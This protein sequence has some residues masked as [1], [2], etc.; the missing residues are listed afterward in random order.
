MSRRSARFGHPENN[1]VT[2]TKKQ[3]SEK[4]IFNEFARSSNLA[5]EFFESRYSPEPDICSRINGAL[6]YFEISHAADELFQ[7]ISTGDNPNVQANCPLEINTVE[8]VLRSLERKLVE[9]AE[10]GRRYKTSCT[11]EINLL[12]YSDLPLQRNVID[13]ISKVKDLADRLSASQFSRVW[14]FDRSYGV[15]GMLES[16]TVSCLTG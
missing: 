15:V 14:I 4:M 16:G 9:R 10:K 13:A 5:V 7:E 6:R 1:L 2:D 12:V 3:R 8:N 11:S